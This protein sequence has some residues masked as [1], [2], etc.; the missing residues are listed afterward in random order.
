MLEWY[1]GPRANCST[2]RTRCCYRSLRLGIASAPQNF[3]SVG[4]IAYYVS[5]HHGLRDD[6]GVLRLVDAVVSQR[7]CVLLV[8]MLIRFVPVIQYVPQIR[9]KK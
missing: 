3:P 6:Y 1:L 2:C 4:L 5:D 9:K 8:L 7:S